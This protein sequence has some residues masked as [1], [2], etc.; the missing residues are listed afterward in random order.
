[1]RIRRKF[2]R[3]W[4]YPAPGDVRLIGPYLSKEEAEDDL[5]GLRRFFESIGVKV[6]RRKP[7][8]KSTLPIQSRL[9]YDD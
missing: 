8:S 5:H 3:W 4:I 7:R 1:M 9:F 6:R 2:R